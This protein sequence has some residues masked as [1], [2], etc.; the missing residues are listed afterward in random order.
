[1]SLL[2]PSPV[3]V[4]ANN[5]ARAAWADVPDSVR[6][7]VAARVGSAI[8]RADGVSA[9][10]NPGF[11]GALLFADGHREFVKAV[12]GAAHAEAGRLNR[13]EAAANLALPPGVP[14]PRLLWSDEYEPG[15]ES[16]WVVTSFEFVPGRAPAAPWTPQDL[17]R[18][19]DALTDLARHEVAPGSLSTFS[20]EHASVLVQWQEFATLNAAERAAASARAG[21]LGTWACRN[22]DVLAEWAAR[23]PEATRGAALVHGD[24]RADNLILDD[25]LA[26][27]V[28]WPYASIGAPW[29]D[30]ACFLPS[31]EMQ[32]GGPCQENF[33]AH[34]LARGVAHEDVRALLAALTGYFFVHAL[35]PEVPE[36]PTL[37]AFQWAQAVPAIRWL[38]ALEPGIAP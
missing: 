19:L 14:A 38:C 1:M 24:F 13:A 11:A 18:A 35:L 4:V 27:I 2:D 5:P 15:D 3:A 9:G 26:W 32:G 37:R 28:D 33:A 7:L 23:A 6:E 8:V 34:P 22:A 12:D 10:F 21:A 31:V 16:A 36:I 20:D 17:G 25:E 29:V 30:L